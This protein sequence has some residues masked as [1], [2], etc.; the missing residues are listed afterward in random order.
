MTD[1][2][3]TSFKGSFQRNSPGD[4]KATQTFAVRS[5]TRHL[6]MVRGCFILSFKYRKNTDKYLEEAFFVLK[7][8]KG[9]ASHVEQGHLDKFM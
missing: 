3:A 6:S 2:S 5:V 4:Q 8:N 7:H 9:S 1:S